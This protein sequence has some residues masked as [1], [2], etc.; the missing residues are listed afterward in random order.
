MRKDT[1]EKNTN[2]TDK[3]SGKIVRKAKTLTI[4]G[5]TKTIKEWAKFYNQNYHTVMS[6]IYSGMD[7]EEALNKQIF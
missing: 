4:E 6:R 1:Q 3:A 2:S 7:P 5:Q